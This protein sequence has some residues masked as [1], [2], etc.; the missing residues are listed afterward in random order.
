[1]ALKRKQP[2]DTSELENVFRSAP[3]EDRSSK[4][5]GYFSPTL[6]PKELQELA[7]IQG[8]SHKILGWRRE[9]NQQS[10]TKA[11][12]YITG[13]DDDGE[14]YGGKKVEKVLELS[15][16]VGACV[17][18]R[19]YGGVMLGPARFTHIE[20][21]AQ[22]AIHRWEDH[23]V[24]ERAKRQK[25]ANEEAERGRLVKTLEDRD[26]SIVVLRTLALEKE[27][28][29]TAE[30]PSSTEQTSKSAVTA[31]RTQVQHTPDYG[32]MQLERLR[33]LDKARDATL[34]FLLKRIDK[35]EAAL[36]ASKAASVEK[37]P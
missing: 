34:S 11:T 35:A 17:V 1:M 25:I 32:A 29:V 33:A 10:I 14:K 37:P 16:A 22:E 23:Q 13:S 2:G 27:Q 6:T 8:A 30:K 20:T 31:S 18:A 24:E 9:S 15:R 28:A 36:A 4:F 5:I 21:C 19:W 7:E 26:N 3:I 12:R